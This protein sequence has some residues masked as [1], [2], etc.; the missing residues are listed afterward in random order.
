MPGG[1]VVAGAGGVAGEGKRTAAL[2]AMLAA[3]K[4]RG[5]G[6]SGSRSASPSPERGS[7]GDPLAEWRRRAAAKAALLERGYAPAPP[8]EAEGDAWS[9][10][11]SFSD[12]AA[13][14]AAAAQRAAS[15]DAPRDARAADIIARDVA[16]ALAL[17]RSPPA[18]PKTRP[19]PL[20]KAT[21]VTRP[22]QAHAPAAPAASRPPARVDAEAQLP[23]PARDAA[24]AAGRAAERT[25]SVDSD[26]SAAEG[27]QQRVARVLAASAAVLDARGAEEE[28]IAAALA[29]AAA[30]QALTDDEGGPLRRAPLS[31]APL[32]VSPSPPRPQLGMGEVEDAL[33]AWRRRRRVR[34][35][36]GCVVSEAD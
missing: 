15:P 14:F 10:H 34:L 24:S 19:A 3:L 13:S 23:P 36:Q 33:T 26:P 4:R 12:C 30:P 29:L 18:R 8:A 17:A 5:R 6:A 21:A 25:P 35:R 31:P 27:L 11:A 1:G 16:A 7:G 2:R 20:S 22:P 28:R 32:R 9:E